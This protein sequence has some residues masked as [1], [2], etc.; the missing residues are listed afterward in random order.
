M[1]GMGSCGFKIADEDFIVALAHGFYD[2]YP[3]QTG[4]P[5]TYVRPNISHISYIRPTAG[6]HD[7]GCGPASAC[8]GDVDI[9]GNLTLTG[10]ETGTPCV[11]RRSLLLVRLSFPSPLLRLHK[12]GANPL[13][14]VGGKSVKVKVADRCG[15]CEN[16]Y[17]IDMPK[18]A[19]EKLGDVSAGRIHGVS[20]TLD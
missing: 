3:G 20:W 1:G 18:V 12:T 2:G 10:G 16:P 15:D 8:A 17:S 7:C 4:N 5:N 9:I 6:N 13:F 11:A 19:F 14:L